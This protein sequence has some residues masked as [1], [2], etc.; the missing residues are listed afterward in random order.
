[1]EEVG[2]PENI[3]AFMNVEH[4]VA[5]A[6]TRYRIDGLRLRHDLARFGAAGGDDAIGVGAQH[7]IGE[8]VLGRPE[9]GARLVELR[10]RRA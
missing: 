8:L 7:G 3:S 6:V 5:G 2:P 1:V 9:L 4:R 10:L